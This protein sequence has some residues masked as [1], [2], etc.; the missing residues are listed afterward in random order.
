MIRVTDITISA[1]EKYNPSA[2]Q[3]RTII[4]ML[5]KIGVD[6]IELPVSAYKKIGELNI[7]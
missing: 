1:I 2:E 4:E 6:F 5:I 7:V 3:L